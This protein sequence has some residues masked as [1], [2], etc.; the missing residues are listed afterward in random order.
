MAKYSFKVYLKNGSSKTIIPASLKNTDLSDFDNF[1]LNLKDRFKL[2]N[3]LANELNINSSDITNITILRLTKQVEFSVIY[4][5]KYLLPVITDLKIKTI[6]TDTYQKNVVAI[7]QNNSSFLEM[8]SY[9]LDNIKNN[10]QQFLTDIYNYNNE[11]SKLL[12]QYGS[13]YHQVVSEEDERNLKELENK[14]Y[15]ELSVYKNYRGLCKSRLKSETYANYK[16]KNNK[17]NP[18]SNLTISKNIKTSAPYTFDKDLE[19]A[20]QTT[21]YNEEYDEFLESYEYEEMLGDGYN[22]L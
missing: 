1:T 2:E 9:L 15:Q 22:K 12:Y 6:S 3:T 16:S 17:S 20:K 11:F 19:V 21:I 13:I 4:N 7:D 18:V 8:K 10:Y 14:I 5:N